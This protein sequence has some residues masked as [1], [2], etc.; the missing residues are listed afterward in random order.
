M[1]E[2]PTVEQQMVEI[3]RDGTI[4]PLQLFDECTFLNYMIHQAVYDYCTARGYLPI[5][6]LDPDIN[7][8][9]FHSI[10]YPKLDQVWRKGIADRFERGYAEEEW[11]LTD[12]SLKDMFVQH[13]AAQGIAAELNVQCEAGT[14]DIVTADTI[15]D[16]QVRLARESLFS[17]VGR[18][19]CYREGINPTANVMIVATRSLV[20]GLHELIGKLG[21]RVEIW[22]PE[23]E[24]TDG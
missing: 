21:V 3:T 11:F 12:Q 4:T 1:S 10:I 24:E 7:M 5:I 16:V 20:P 9:V 14:A 22:W 6:T 13:L 23:G 15:Y 18:L 17:A 8:W 2:L 19:L